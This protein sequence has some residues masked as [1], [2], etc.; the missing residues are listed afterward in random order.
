MK[1]LQTLLI[2][3][4][5]SA[6][7]ILLIAC[8]GKNNDKPSDT[9]I[10]DEPSISEEIVEDTEVLTPVS[11]I[12]SE[13]ITDDVKVFTKEEFNYGMALSQYFYTSGCVYQYENIDFTYLNS[14]TDLNVRSGEYQKPIWA[15][16]AVDSIDEEFESLKFNVED[17]KKLVTWLETYEPTEEEYPGYRG[18]YKLMA[19]YVRLKAGLPLNFYKKEDAIPLFD[20]IEGI[21]YS[22][23][24]DDPYYLA[25][26]MYY[27]ER[28]KD[29]S[30]NDMHFQNRYYPFNVSGDG[31]LSERFADSLENREIAGDLF[32][33]M[34]GEHSRY[35]NMLWY[36]VQGAGLTRE[37]LLACNEENIGTYKEANKLTEEQIDALLI[38]D[39][40]EARKALKCKYNLFSPVDT[41]VYNLFELKNMTKEEFKALGFETD[42]I[43]NCLKAIEEVSEEE[44]YGFLM[45]A[46]YIRYMVDMPLKG[47]DL[48]KLGFIHF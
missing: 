9:Q 2:I 17:I 12:N 5:L 29:S 26:I 36:F 32:I 44:D 34:K 8:A 18:E 16:I 4:A 25:Y 1:K 39:E 38:E 28:D 31:A 19:E 27:I 30:I 45:V 37:D 3:L 41:E 15:S 40:T 43:N 24:T 47:Y 48:E 6:A 11:D 20:I 22:K 10:K 46:E 7:V 13:P 23:F 21:D 33:K 14:R 42:D 35:K